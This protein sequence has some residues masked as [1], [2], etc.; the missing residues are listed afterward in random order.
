MEY[1]RNLEI[2]TRNNMKKNTEVEEIYEQ[3]MDRLEDLLNNPLYEKM[4]NE[5]IHSLFEANDERIK[6]ALLVNEDETCGLL[7]NP[8]VFGQL[9][10]MFGFL[11][12]HFKSP[13]IAARLNETLKV[14]K[15]GKGGF[16][17]CKSDLDGLSSAVNEANKEV[18]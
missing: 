4:S 15:D 16:V 8:I 5:E 17:H 11:Q 18:Q 3:Y 12:K 9:Y 6:T 14:I 10:E 2:M 7:S 13:K 1:A